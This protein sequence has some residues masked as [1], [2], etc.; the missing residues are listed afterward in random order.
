MLTEIFFHLLEHP[1]MGIPWQTL[2]V[3]EPQ[4][5]VPPDHYFTKQ[6]ALRPWP[7]SKLL[8]LRL[9]PLRTINLHLIKSQVHFLTASME[10]VARVFSLEGGRNPR[11][12]N[13]SPGGEALDEL[14]GFCF[15]SWMNSYEQGTEET[16]SY[17]LAIKRDI[18]EATEFQT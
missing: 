17:W 2:P 9:S 16:K 10:L 14:P 11:G 12:R 8:S 3:W 4:P 7:A 13:S 5:V 15:W 18:L 6:K 1:K